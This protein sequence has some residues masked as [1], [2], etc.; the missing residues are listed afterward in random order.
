MADEQ[1]APESVEV[2]E[3][4][5]F[6]P[7]P[8]PEL[9]P[10][11]SEKVEAEVEARVQQVRAAAPN[12][13]ISE[14]EKGRQRAVVDQPMWLEMPFMPGRQVPAETMSDIVRKHAE[15]VGAEDLDTLYKRFEDIGLSLEDIQK[16]IGVDGMTALQYRRSKLEPKDE[17]GRSLYVFEEDEDKLRAKIRGDVIKEFAIARKPEVAPQIGELGEGSFED[18]E[19][20][21]DDHSISGVKWT[22]NLAVGR[23]DSETGEPVGEYGYRMAAKI[24]APLIERDPGFIQHV[25]A[26]GSRQQGIAPYVNFR[27]REER[28]RLGPDWDPEKDKERVTKEALRQVPA[29]ITLGL[30]SAPVFMNYDYDE[31]TGR[32]RIVPPEEMDVGDILKKQ[33]QIIGYNRNGH[34]VARTE[35]NAEYVFDIADLLMSFTAGAV[36][37]GFERWVQG[38]KDADGIWSGGKAGMA[39]REWYGELAMDN[40]QWIEENPIRGSMLVAGTA[41][42]TFLHPDLISISMG[43][44]KK[45]ATHVAK[46]AM[47]DDIVNV[48][49]YLAELAQA[50]S[51]KDYTRVNEIE[52]KL[53]DEYPDLAQDVDRYTEEATARASSE[54]TDLKEENVKKIKEDLPAEL[55]DYINSPAAL[56]KRLLSF[57]TK[58]GAVTQKEAVALQ[59]NELFDTDAILARIDEQI[60]KLEDTNPEVLTG[61]LFQRNR[62]LFLDPAA[63]KSKIREGLSKG[64]LASEEAQIRFA[65]WLRDNAHRAL[66]D[67]DSFFASDGILATAIRPGGEAEL[68]NKK[69]RAWVYK[70]YLGKGKNSLQGDVRDILSADN[71]PKNTDKVLGALR[72]AREVAE[73]SAAL[74][75]VGAGAVYETIRGRFP[76][77]LSATARKLAK[78]PVVG[79]PLGVIASVRSEAIEPFAGVPD[80]DWKVREILELSDPA[81][82]FSTDLQEVMGIS[83]REAG[84]LVRVMDAAMQRVSDEMGISIEE[85]WRHRIAGI[86]RH[87]HDQLI[88]YWRKLHPDLTD[89]ELRKLIPAL[90]GG[91]PR[92]PPK[93]KRKPPHKNL[94]KARKLLKNSGLEGWKV[95]PVDYQLKGK[96]LYQ[97]QDADGK[98]YAYEPIRDPIIE[99]YTGREIFTDPFLF[100]RSPEL[101]EQFRD[102][103]GVSG[104]PS[105]TD[106][107]VVVAWFLKDHKSREWF[108]RGR[109]PLRPLESGRGFRGRLPFR[110]PDA[111][112]PPT[113]PTPASKEPA[114]EAP[115]E[116]PKPS[117]EGSPVIDMG[118]QYERTIQTRRARG[119]KTDPRPFGRSDDYGLSAEEL[120]A[121]ILSLGPFPTV[122]EV[123]RWLMENS[124]RPDTQAILARILPALDEASGFPVGT[125]SMPG[126]QGQ[127]V[128]PEWEFSPA[129]TDTP[130]MRLL[131]TEGEW[132]REAIRLYEEALKS[133]EFKPIHPVTGAAITVPTGPDGGIIVRIVHGSLSRPDWAGATTFERVLRPNFREILDEFYPH[134]EGKAWQ[135]LSKTMK[136]KILEGID[137]AFVTMPARFPSEV[138]LLGRGNIYTGLS[139]KTIVH[140]F[141]H[142]ATSYRIGAGIYGVGPEADKARKIIDEMI[143]IR[144][145]ALTYVN[146]KLKENPDYFG[147]NS[148]VFRDYV[149]RFRKRKTYDN[150][151]RIVDEIIS[152]AF[153]DP[154]FQRLL[155]EVPL[156]KDKTAWSRFV[157]TIVGLLGFGPKD[158]S[159]LSRVIR[160]SD[161]L[162]ETDIT[163]VSF[164]ANDFGGL[165][166]SAAEVDDVLG[167]V[168]A[169]LKRPAGRLRQNLEDGI[170][171]TAADGTVTSRLGEFIDPEE[172]SRGPRFIR[173]EQG[174]L[175]GVTAEGFPNYRV[176]GEGYY[177]LDQATDLAGMERLAQD[178]NALPWFHGS[179]QRTIT[180]KD[181]E[182]Q[183]SGT[184]SGNMLGPG[185]YLTSDPERALYYARSIYGEG[186]GVIKS[187]ELNTRKILDLRGSGEDLIKQLREAGLAEDSDVLRKL[188][189]LAPRL[190]DDITLAES[191]VRTLLDPYISARDLW[192]RLKSHPDMT[193]SI[194]ELL[195][196]GIDGVHH[197]GNLDKDVLVLFDPNANSLNGAARVLA[198][199]N[200]QILDRTLYQTRAGSKLAETEFLEDGRALIRVWENADASSIMHEFAHILRRD[201]SNESMEE[202]VS[203]VI[204][205]GVDVEINPRTGGFIGAPGEVRKAEELF[206]EAF[207]QYVREG[208]APTVGLKDVFERLKKTMVAIY[209]SVIGSDEPIVEINDAVRRVFDELLGQEPVPEVP[210]TRMRRIIDAIRKNVL[211]LGLPT[212]DRST[213]KLIIAEARRLGVPLPIAR[214][215]Q[216]IDK[217]IEDGQVVFEKPITSLLERGVGFES[218]DGKHVI[219]LDDVQTHDLWFD[220][221]KSLRGLRGT[222]PAIART[223]SEPFQL[224]GD[225][226]PALKSSPV[227]W[228]QDS[229]WAQSVV[230]KYV[231]T[232][233]F[234]GDQVEDLR[235]LGLP[236]HV[237]RNILAVVR[238]VQQVVGDAITI[239][240]KTP[241]RM[242]KFLSGDASTTFF[243]GRPALS[244]GVNYADNLKSLL[245]NW[246]ESLDAQGIR[247]DRIAFQR[248]IKTVCALM[249]DPKATQNFGSIVS[250]AADPLGTLKE[251]PG[252]LKALADEGLS[253][254]PRNVRTGD[255]LLGSLD[256]IFEGGGGIPTIEFFQ[257]LAHATNLKVNNNP[258]LRARLL[259]TT[260]YHF[261]FTKR[262]G[263]FYP[264]Y[265]TGTADFEAAMDQYLNSIEVIFKSDVTKQHAAVMVATYGAT[266]HARQSLEGLGIFADSG[267]IKLF[268]EWMDGKP[269]PDEARHKVR[270]LTERLGLNPNFTDKGF[271][272]LLG[273]DFYI[274]EAVRLR[275][276]QAVSQ[277]WVRKAYVGEDVKKVGGVGSW[278]PDILVEGQGSG[279]VAADLFRIVYRDLKTLI[280]RGRHL[281]RQVYFFMN[282][283]D[284]LWQ[285]ALSHGFIPAAASLTRLTAHQIAVLPGVAH[286][287]WGVTRIPRLVDVIENPEKVFQKEPDWMF[288]VM[289]PDAMERFRKFLQ[290]GGDAFVHKLKRVLTDHPVRWDIKVNP[291]MRGADEVIVVGTRAYKAKDVRRVFLEEGIFAS[292]DTR[293]LEGI[294]RNEQRLLR[295]RAG[296]GATSAKIRSIYKNLEDLDARRLVEN[297]AEAWSERERTGLAVTMMELGFDPRQAARLTIDALYDYAG[298]MSRLDR[299]ILVNLMYPFWAFQKNANRHMF[300]YILSPWGAYRLNVA[301]KIGQYGPEYLS[302]VLYEL[303]IDPYG[304]DTQA[305]SEEKPDVFM[306]YMQF[307]NTIENGYGRIETLTKE[308]RR[309][310]ADGGGAIAQDKAFGLTEEEIDQW[311]ANLSEEDRNFIENGYGGVE[312]VP[313]RIV[314]FL[315][316]M[317][318][319]QNQLF[320]GGEV[321]EL[322]PDMKFVAGVFRD[323]RGEGFGNVK[324]FDVS[325]FHI[326]KP[327]RDHRRIFMQNRPSIAVT[328][329]RKQIVR[330]YYKLLYDSESPHVR[331]TPY[332]EVTLPEPTV[333]A[334]MEWMA[335]WASLHLAL[336]AEGSDFVLGTE[337]GSDWIGVTAALSSLFPIE[338]A[339]MLEPLL[340]KMQGFDPAPYRI[341]PT[342]VKQMEFWLPQSPILRVDEKLLEVAGF[343]SD[344]FAQGNATIPI[345][346]VKRV[347]EEGLE[348]VEFTG[349]L[350]GVAPDPALF[351]AAKEDRFYL[352][353]GI[354]SWSARYYL[355]DINR[356]LFQMDAEGLEAFDR[357]KL[358]KTLERIGIPSTEVSRLRTATAESYR[359]QKL[360][361]DE[362]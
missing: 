45:V 85:A 213:A 307:R 19:I 275:I 37:G 119:N 99:P 96:P 54:F 39:R 216:L 189:A 109:V 350:A 10:Y 62:G 312:N 310:I 83:R 35:G 320:R 64:Q 187:T 333:F 240:T 251:Y 303:T 126:R 229:P 270:A 88:R 15:R 311:F 118:A 237:M 61:L 44:R 319:G 278:L 47:D 339:P 121:G 56:R 297:T 317:F 340:S 258:V 205:K 239:A 130:P 298:S 153:T 1:I 111:E 271:D 145:K 41:L 192:T 162:L 276:A 222:D 42:T 200:R 158:N 81:K 14:M 28:K 299:S 342:L 325:P 155:S 143:G 75:A 129:I 3:T 78:T 289:R 335:G 356:M 2:L 17:K 292:F 308:Q 38:D 234:G 316:L 183:Y 349:P 264:G 328:H 32:V 351:A 112:A 362:Q 73:L 135:D 25:E 182:I 330:D 250:S 285:T 180:L 244:S 30:W 144:D 194:E 300:N 156:G 82:K 72:R 169:T 246:W 53:Y 253:G 77:V 59:R 235:K 263:K 233:F 269:I 206:A 236:D 354:V 260:M 277:A 168:N 165:G 91:T 230:G 26:F 274:P 197:R 188:Q 208:R 97:I 89:D 295:Q 245:D 149:F 293:A 291:I 179:P 136:T 132:H 171:T 196:A 116:R 11:D 5:E 93:A 57:T 159:A 209:R 146:K 296:E 202:I 238:P 178:I 210:N 9:P 167:A 133:G 108:L 225:L 117:Y 338:R 314:R 361:E 326:P 282:W 185:L 7:P 21:P 12:Q 337:V 304:I 257:G 290:G 286:A 323:P 24:V 102:R 18:I 6:E 186:A 227:N 51:R 223:I 220:Q 348:T 104:G 16:S 157:E 141:L 329:R 13:L 191:V 214:A 204:A 181:Y 43:L 353:P 360:V 231:L 176:M 20:L 221:E 40:W 76:R 306:N 198:T 283:N 127:W 242:G 65:S 23:I 113:P 309:M 175:R 131:Q 90:T 190:F 288:P 315:R 63:P 105:H 152:F 142:V 280:T 124:K 107:E 114:P 49:D 139:E 86:E 248:V 174:D 33:I 154:D 217:L 332:L 352:L 341:H 259:E 150:R 172:V 79:K 334:A 106:P 336:V 52:R 125:A 98:P 95:V 170:L 100:P 226:P 55:H 138:Q 359:Q 321:L 122:P 195:N 203:W 281:F 134:V 241:E 331:D 48:T 60:A 232:I 66:R 50:R 347:D 87:D 4:P 92:R 346:P 302:W 268:K 254:L 68:L 261:G 218:A 8:E 219:S 249:Q 322:S 327:N 140:E 34:I 305:L 357:G 120:E 123:A 313:P 58:E 70:N 103:M 69:A 101:R 80:L 228:F 29:L 184:G 301:R 255:E 224:E 294:I 27:I 128:L 252:F 355:G 201:L 215:D 284:H 358:V 273:A 287:I 94:S 247:T 318:S 193:K 74:R 151:A 266:Y 243:E 115:P 199:E 256:K 267:T 36:K 148:T 160:L 71:L 161:E 164:W 265:D 22:P 67:P 345:K 31:E 262:N 272:E 177:E 344:P 147:V 324:P 212:D 207:E 46:L 137:A 173:T 211:G 163:A 84:A 110:G 279:N 166:D 343:D